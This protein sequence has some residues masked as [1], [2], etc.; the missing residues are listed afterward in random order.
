MV[1]YILYCTARVVQTQHYGSENKYCC[2]LELSYMINHIHTQK[3][4]LDKHMFGDHGVLTLSVLAV[5]TRWWNTAC[6]Q[7]CQ[8]YGMRGDIQNK[9]W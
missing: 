7:L 6:T 5:L 9:Q 4:H 1:W 3:C 2:L 8:C